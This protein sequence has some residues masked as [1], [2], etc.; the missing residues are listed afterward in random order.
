MIWIDWIWRDRPGF[1]FLKNSED[2]EDVFGVLI[3]FKGRL[4]DFGIVF[5]I[6][7]G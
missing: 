6:G 5:G 1:V 4:N 2:F 3:E 7:R